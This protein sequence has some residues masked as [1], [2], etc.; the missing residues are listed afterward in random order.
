MKLIFY[1]N[2]SLPVTRCFDLKRKIIQGKIPSRK[3]LSPWQIHRCVLTTITHFKFKSPPPE[4]FP[5]AD[6]PR[7]KKF[8]LLHI[9]ENIPVKFILIKES[10]RRIPP[11]KP[12]QPDNSPLENFRQL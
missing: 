1:D 2:T 10:L 7:V 9:K 4:K 6:L 12:I 8:F 3:L 5:N 11:E